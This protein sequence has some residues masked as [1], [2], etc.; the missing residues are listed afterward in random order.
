MARQTREIFRRGTEPPVRVAEMRDTSHLDIGCRRPA[1]SGAVPRVPRRALLAGGAAAGTTA[2]AGCPNTGP[3]SG[4]HPVPAL[5]GHRGCAAENPENTVAAV[6]AA[7]RVVD[8]V[9]VD[10]RRCATGEAVVFH[11]ETLDRL[12][13]ASG[14]V[15]ET[16]CETL[17]DL[18]VAGSGETIPTLEEVFDALD[19]AVRL[20]LD[21]KDP[22]LAPV[23]LHTSDAYHHDVLLSSFNREVLAEVADA[24]PSAPTA[25]IVRESPPN[26]ALRPLVPGAPGWLYAPEDVGG[27]VDEALALGCEAIHPRYELCLRTDL[28]ERCHEAGLRVEAWTITSGRELDALRGVGVDGVIAD[29]C[30]GLAD[31]VDVRTDRG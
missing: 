4:D 10:V 22:G 15:S 31:R 23:V 16:P 7:A 8:A 27:K 3:A 17:L 6:R 26:R 2:L 19:P 12:T 13:D 29:V 21:L 24:D 30:A 5:I 11:D 18:E 9:E 28:V 1:V 20:V 14:R 25:L